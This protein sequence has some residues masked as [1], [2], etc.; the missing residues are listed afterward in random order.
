MTVS[1]INPCVV[2]NTNNWEVFKYSIFK[3]NFES[4]YI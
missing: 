4:W 1:S 2:C 3:Q